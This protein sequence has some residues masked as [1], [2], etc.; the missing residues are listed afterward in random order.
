MSRIERQCKTAI[1]RSTPSEANV[2][3]SRHERGGKS[4]SQTSQEKEEE[5]IY[6]NKNSLLKL[7][8]LLPTDPYPQQSPKVTNPH[9]PHYSGTPRVV[10]C[11]VMD[12]F[13]RVPVSPVRRGAKSRVT[14]WERGE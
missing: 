6:A 2:D 1:C 13:H 4:R 12:F 8:L 11:A 10:C 5:K 14:L 7:K 3:S 9:T